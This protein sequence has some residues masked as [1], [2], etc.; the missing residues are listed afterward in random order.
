VD[1]DDVEEEV[2][3]LEELR[4]PLNLLLTLMPRWR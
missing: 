1:P 3:R 4:G 2:E